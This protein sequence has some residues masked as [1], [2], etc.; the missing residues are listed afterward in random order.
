MT[1]YHPPSQDPDGGWYARAARER[2]EADALAEIAGYGAIAR[3][4]VTGRIGFSWGS[5]SSDQAEYLALQVLREFPDAATLA[6]GFNTYVALATGDGGAWHWARDQSGGSAMR[7]AF[8]E[9][10]KRS[11][12]CRISVVLNTRHGD[13]TTHWDQLQHDYFKFPMGAT[14]SRDRRYWWIAGHDDWSPIPKAY[15]GRISLVRSGDCWRLSFNAWSVQ[16]GWETIQ[17]CPLKWDDLTRSERISQWR[18]RPRMQR[19]KTRRG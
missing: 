9:C 8:S 13:E 19:S 1:G 15:D 2:A 11:Q 16:N 17:S 4:P 14:V 3:S 7:V 6:W 12:N 18:F 5:S 10:A